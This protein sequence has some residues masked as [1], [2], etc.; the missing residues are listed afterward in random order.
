MPTAV[1]APAPPL[2]P[3]GES[4]GS[5]GLRVMPC[6]SL[7]VNQRS[8]ERGDVGPPDDDTTPAR[9]SA[10]T[11]ALSSDA[12]ASFIATRPLVVA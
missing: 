10:A 3:P 7:P 4:F 5:H 8:G 6:R 12:K 9:R 11:G 1:A 2:E